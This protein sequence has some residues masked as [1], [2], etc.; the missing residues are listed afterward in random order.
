MAYTTEAHLIP[1]CISLHFFSIRPWEYAANTAVVIMP[2]WNAS[3]EICQFVLWVT[4]WWD[5]FLLPEQI[6]SH[7]PRKWIGGE[8]GMFY[9]EMQCGCFV[10][11]RVSPTVSEGIW[12]FHKFSADGS[13]SDTDNV[14]ELFALFPQQFSIRRCHYNTRF[15]TLC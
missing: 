15:V 3:L 11:K 9:F 4:W 10:L 14:F 5:W 2:K 1:A 6:D 13:A 12:V 8:K 7:S